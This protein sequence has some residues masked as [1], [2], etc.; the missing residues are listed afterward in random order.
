MTE[1][2]DLR[3][4]LEQLLQPVRDTAAYTARLVKHVGERL[5]AMSLDLARDTGAIVRN[6]KGLADAAKDQATTV[7]RATHARS[8][9]G[10]RAEARAG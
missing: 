8:L 7:S 5:D 3:S 1:P 10:A 2:Q 9:R 6:A 4:A